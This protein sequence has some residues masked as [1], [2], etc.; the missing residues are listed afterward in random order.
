[1]TGEYIWV[2]VCPGC[3]IQHLLHLF[4]QGVIKK[5]YIKEHGICKFCGNPT[6]LEME[7]WV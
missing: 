1:M 3:M 2:K 4:L 6:K 7:T 5:R